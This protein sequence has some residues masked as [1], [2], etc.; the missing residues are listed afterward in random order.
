LKD[1]H[2]A[3]IQYGM[4]MYSSN[5]PGIGG[6]LKL[7]FED[8]IVEEISPMREVL[9]VEDWQTSDPAR[10][11]QGERAKNIHLTVQ[12]MGLSTFDV[13]A[14]LASSLKIS[15][16]YVGYAGLKDK[17]AL[18]TQ[19]M[20][21]PSKTIDTLTTLMLSRIDIRNL[22]YQRRQIEIGDLWG[23]RFRVALRNSE[24]VCSE[25]SDALLKLRE[26]PLLNYFGVQRFGVNRPQTHLVG[27]ALVKK[28]LEEAIKIML[29][30][31]SEHDPDELTDA[32]TK[33]SEDM[34]P[35]ERIIDAFPRE[36]R[37]ERDVL[38]YLAKH[39]NDYEKAFSKVPPRVQ[40]LFVHAFQSYLFN[41]FISERVKSGMS[42]DEPESGDFLFQLNTAHSGRDSWLYVS[43]SSIEERR[44]QV[45][46]GEFGVAGPVP[47]FSTKTPPSTQAEMLKH[48]LRE[49]GI[50]LQDFHNPTKRKLDS[51]GGLHLVSIKVSDLKIQCHEDRFV[52]EFSLPKG[53]YATVVMR[54]VMRNHPINRI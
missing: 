39:E 17:R 44:K 50:E 31:T 24:A 38:T 18:T 11:V 3:E 45:K 28:D 6:N 42:V 27:K 7:R 10:V 54:E 19:R 33:L 5:L 34:K 46:S 49:E 22:T 1:A 52:F 43:E 4:E 32:R 35:N 21:V 51:P 14:I 13:A 25:S 36:L 8:F 47:G 29:T 2:P 20:S 53:S 48:I 30:T 12:K 15:R 16:G 37:Y 9:R 23:N 41:R 26:I 40:T